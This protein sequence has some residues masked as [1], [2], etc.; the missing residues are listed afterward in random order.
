MSSHHGQ[1]PDGVLGAAYLAGEQVPAPTQVADALSYALKVFFAG[2]PRIKPTCCTDMSYAGSYTF[3]RHSSFFIVYELQKQ[4]LL[5]P[6]FEA[7]RDLGRR[8]VINSSFVW[9]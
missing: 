7:F 4:T 1:G 8:N 9:A 3:P 5:A 2:A 6:Q